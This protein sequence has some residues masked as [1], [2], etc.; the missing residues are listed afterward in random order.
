MPNQRVV[1]AGKVWTAAGVSAGIDLAL[2]LFGEIA[3]QEEAEVAQLI[4]EYDPQ[5][6]FDAGHPSKASEIVRHKAKAEM[7]RLSR[8]PRNYVSALKI[9]WRT[10]IDRS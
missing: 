9:L 6:P 8:N 2:A 5:P 7:A 10:A 1:R 4:I 3:S